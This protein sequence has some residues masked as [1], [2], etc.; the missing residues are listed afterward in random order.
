MRPLGKKVCSCQ[1]PVLSPDRGGGGG[2]HKADGVPCSTPSVQSRGRGRSKLADGIQCS[3]PGVQCCGGRGPGCLFGSL[4]PEGWCLRHLLNRWVK[5]PYYGVRG[6]LI[7]R[8]APLWLPL[9][10]PS[11]CFVSAGVDALHIGRRQGGPQIV[12]VPR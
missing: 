2:V 10:R 5:Q 9:D 8:V 4:Q 3:T 1:G 11:P 7:S 6:T 12:L